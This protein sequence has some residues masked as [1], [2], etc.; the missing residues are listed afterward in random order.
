MKKGTQTRRMPMLTL[1]LTA[2]LAIGG[3]AGAITDKVDPK[4][5]DQSIVYLDQSVALS[6]LQTYISPADPYIR[7]LTAVV[8]PFRVEQ[9]L[10]HP[11]LIGRQMA[12]VL[13][14]TWAQRR[15][16]PTLVIASDQL[17]RSQDQALRYARSRGADLVITGR[18][19]HFMDGGLRASSSIST[20]VEI[21]D[22]RNGAKIWS[23]AQAG[24]IQFKGEQDNI[25][26][27]ADV[28]MPE[29]PTTVL[30]QA[31]GNSMADPLEEWTGGPQQ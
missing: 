25:F 28:R 11:R 3:C 31:I 12:A 1:L 19:T 30:M 20:Q 15:L 22:V 10:A 27:R 17:Y 5:T 24:R 6:R 4:I 9:H 16:F 7:P 23:M 2:V 21:F 14:Q 29:N 13:H 8:L 26:F 18:I